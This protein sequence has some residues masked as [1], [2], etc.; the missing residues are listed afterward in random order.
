MG[1]Q[2]LKLAQLYYTIGV[3][4]TVDIKTKL[5]QDDILTLNADD[6]SVIP[7]Q[8]TFSNKVE[9]ITTD[10]PDKDGIYTVKNKETLLKNLSY[11]YNRNESNL[12]YFDLSSI[13]NASIE[14]VVGSTLQDIK[15]TTNVNELWKWFVIFALAFLIIEM[16]ILKFFK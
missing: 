6:R 3:E 11:N 1:K 2:S 9:L 16:L 7:L 4:N 8:R 5:S 14:N 15:S 12:N 13:K 10:F